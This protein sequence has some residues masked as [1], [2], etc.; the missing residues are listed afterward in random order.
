MRPARLRVAIFSN[1]YKPTI[2]GVVT[3]ILLFRHGLLKRGHDVHVFA[4]EV[5]EYEDD[6]PYIFRLPTLLD[7]TRSYELS[8]ALPVK[9]PMRNTIRGIKPHLIHSQH[10]VLMGDLAMRYAQ[11]MGL[12]LVFT[13]HSRYEKIIQ[14][15]VPLFS[16]W[17]GQMAQ[18]IVQDYLDHCAHVIVPTANL[19]D[20]IC[21]DY[22]VDVPITILPTPVDL[23]RFAHLDPASVRQRHQLHEKE[24]L[25]YLGRISPEKGIDLL[26]HSFALVVRQRPQA[27][28]LIVGR[29]PHEENL[30]ELAGDLGLQDQVIFTGAVPYEDVPHYMAAA[31]LFTFTSECETQGLVLIEAMAA[32]TPVVAVH[33]AS[34]DDALDD[35]AAGVLVEGD[36]AAFADAVL[37]ALASPG[38]LDAMCRA[39]QRIVQR[40]SVAAATDRLLE[41]YDQVLAR[42]PRP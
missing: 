21:Q 6:E 10:P 13:F 3:S 17:A 7:L 26:L 27:V 1:A 39:A 16:D 8:L 15:Y 33:A 23:D 12:P 34:S 38:Q 2:S 29:G 22:R 36:E 25:M 11:D 20:L 24:I 4:P 35:G 40:Y 41:V 30:Q 14:H 37:S 18:D 42:G 9:R 5:D 28:L 31:D 19:R 32:G